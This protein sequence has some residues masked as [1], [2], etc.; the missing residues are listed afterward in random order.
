MFGDVLHC[1][2]FFWNSCGF[3]HTPGELL[4]EILS[5]L[6]KDSLC[7]VWISEAYEHC[8]GLF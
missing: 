2:I 1:N 7:F 5:R 4:Q 8:K 3:F 6:L